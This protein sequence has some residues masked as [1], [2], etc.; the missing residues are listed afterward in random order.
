MCANPL[1]QT[2]DFPDEYAP[3]VLFAIPRSEGRSALGIESLLPFDGVDIW[4]AWE[5]TWLD[6]SGKPVAG[7]VRMQINADSPNIVE[8]KS[9]KLYLGSF[10]MTQYE[11]AIDV[12]KIIGKD[13]ADAVDCSIDVAIWTRL[14]EHART[15]R[16]LSLIHI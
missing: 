9:L 12:M 14:R 2:T 4:N 1:G 13:V 6:D 10:A 3:E 16:D 7:T 5:L 11:S 8:S 15:I